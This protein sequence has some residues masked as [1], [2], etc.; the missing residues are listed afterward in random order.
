MRVKSVGLVR[1]GIS[2]IQRRSR[3]H[4]HV[5]FSRQTFKPLVCF[6]VFSL[7]ACARGSHSSCFLLCLY[8]FASFV[9]ASSCALGLSLRGLRTRHFSSFVV[10][11]VACDVRDVRAPRAAPCGPR[12]CV[13]LVHECVRCSVPSL[14]RAVRAL[15]AR[16]R[17][18]ARPRRA[19]NLQKKNRCRDRC[20]LGVVYV[21]GEV[22]DAVYVP[23]RTALWSRE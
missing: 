8:L 5:C 22:R 10:T 2:F 9:A 16:A 4:V 21:R 15:S 23:G 13:T 20:R 19:T 6:S 3:L 7:H 1:I 12:A 18:N 17:N 11:I 14:A